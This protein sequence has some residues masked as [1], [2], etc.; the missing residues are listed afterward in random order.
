MEKIKLAY[1][2]CSWELSNGEYWKAQD[3][4]GDLL[5]DLNLSFA[6]IDSNGLVQLSNKEYNKK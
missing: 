5:T 6:H 4:K 1:I 3:I 2:R